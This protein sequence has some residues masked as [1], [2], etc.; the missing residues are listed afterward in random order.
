MQKFAD[1]FQVAFGQ[2]SWQKLPSGLIVQWGT[3]TNTSGSGVTVTFPIAFPT[4]VLAI[5]LGTDTTGAYLLT[6]QNKSRT[7]FAAQ[8]WVCT[9]G[10][11]I[12]VAGSW[13]AIGY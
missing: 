10:S 1:E 6:Y 11:Q 2:S 4:A 7:A 9:T 13:I 5:S 3:I 12:G 8:G